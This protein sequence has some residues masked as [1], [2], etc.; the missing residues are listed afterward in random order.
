M[1]TINF[2]NWFV[3]Y[4][5]NEGVLQILSSNLSYNAALKLCGNYQEKGINAIYK[6]K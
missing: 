6:S 4:M 1:K 3:Y 5:N 2:N